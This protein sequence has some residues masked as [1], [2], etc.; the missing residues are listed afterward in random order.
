[1]FKK[2]V[3]KRGKANEKVDEMSPYDPS[4]NENRK[5]GA[6]AGTSRWT[7]DLVF[8]FWNQKSQENGNR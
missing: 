1:M 3:W 5:V 4:L 2:R 8:M 6:R 7:T